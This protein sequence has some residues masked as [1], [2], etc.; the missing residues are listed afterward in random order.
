MLELL[1]RTELN[2]SESSVNAALGSHGTGKHK[3][4]TRKTCHAPEGSHKVCSLSMKSSAKVRSRRRL[5]RSESTTDVL[6]VASRSLPPGRLILYSNHLSLS[7]CPSRPSLQRHRS[8]DSE[9]TSVE[10]SQ[11]ERSNGALSATLD[12]TSTHLMQHRISTSVFLPDY[13]ASH[14]ARKRFG[15]VC[16]ADRAAE[17]ACS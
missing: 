10:L 13:S 5:L 3:M 4:Y 17:K 11:L 14:E 9:G 15:D 7:Y 8:S 2:F 1:I 6:T 12:E 16:A